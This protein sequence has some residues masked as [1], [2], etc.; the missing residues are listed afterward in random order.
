MVGCTHSEIE[1]QPPSLRVDPVL[2]AQATGVDARFI[3]ISAVDEGIVW[4]SGTEGTYARTTDG[5]TTWHAGV[6]PDAEALQFRD[7]HAVDA[8]T[9]YLLSIGEG[10]QSRIYKTVDAGATWTLQFTNPEPGGRRSRERSMA[11]P[12]RR[13][14]PRR[15]SLGSVRTA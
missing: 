10:E 6:V 15:R 1:R 4:I 3:G 13:A 14:R 2:T 9:A 8:E 11:Q 5:G 12:T 7:V